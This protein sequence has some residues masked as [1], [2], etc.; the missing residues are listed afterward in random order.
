MST[1]DQLHIVPATFTRRLGA[2]V[3]DSLLLFALL[4][5]ASVPVVMLAGGAESPF[6]QG[7]G[8][9]LYLYIVSFLFFGWFWVHGGQTLGMRSWKLQV[10]RDDGH[11]LGWDSA[12]V[13]FIGATVSLLPLFIGFLWIL[14]NSDRLAWHDLVSKTRIMHNPNL[15]K[16]SDKKS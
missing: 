11:A 14:F 1:D 2:M 4:M 10:V 8:Y 15:G 5:I 3:Y 16:K 12:L 6:I 9:Q 7:A 13:R